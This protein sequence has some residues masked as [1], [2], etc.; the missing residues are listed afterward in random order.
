MSSGYQVKASWEGECG[1]GRDLAAC[2]LDDACRRDELR[3][4]RGH[5]DL[6]PDLHLP[7]NVR[8]KLP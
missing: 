7:G 3:K 2:G 1:W 5:E 4:E 6:T 8:Q